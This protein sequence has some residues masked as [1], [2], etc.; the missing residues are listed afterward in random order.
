MATTMN[1]TV[2][3][4][5]GCTETIPLPDG[6]TRRRQLGRACPQLTYADGRWAREHGTWRLQLEIPFNDGGPREH[7]RAGYPTETQTRDALTTIISLL[8][9]ADTTDEPDTQRRAITALIRERLANK[10]PL[11]D[12]DEIRKR[13]TLGQAVDNP[14]TLGQYLTEWLTT[15]ADL[16]GGT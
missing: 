13:L 11:P 2:F 4:R 15:K 16:A 8:R 10:T 14:L 1:G 3:K 7:L 5:C 9:L 12:E 6:T